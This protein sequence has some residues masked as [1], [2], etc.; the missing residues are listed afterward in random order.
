MVSLSLLCSIVFFSSL[1][2]LR[3]LSFFSL[4]FNFILLSAWTTIQQVLFFLLT[5]TWS[6]HLAEI[7][8]SVSITKSQR[9]FYVSFSW[10]VSG[11]CIYHLLVRS[12][13]NFLH[14]SQ[15][16]TFPTLLCLV[17]Y[18]FCA[19]LLHLLIMWLIIS[20]HLP[21]CCILSILTL[22]SPYGIV[23]H[24]YQKR[25]HFFLEISLSKPCSS[26]LV[27]DFTCLSLEMSLQLF[28]FPF[29]FPGYFCSV[30]ACVVWIIS[31]DC[32]LSFSQLFHVVF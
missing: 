3:Y 25:F 11:L 22:I 28:F 20:S 27:W 6:G 24:Y 19:N 9:I 32:N 31:G 7:R 16:I 26:F 30:D 17:L 1:A 5:F 29:L 15:L 8:G 23:L 21:F 10:M 4:S 13:L 2:R 12:N 18:S 14:N